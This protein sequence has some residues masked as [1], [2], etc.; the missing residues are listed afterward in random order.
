MARLSSLPAKLTP[1][2]GKLPTYALARR[3]PHCGRPTVIVWVQDAKGKW[4]GRPIAAKS[5]E[6]SVIYVPSRHIYHGIKCLYI[7]KHRKETP[8][9]KPEGTQ[10]A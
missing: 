7:D 10:E 6:G 8:A 3:C 2:A 4:H 1:L 9:L 5:W